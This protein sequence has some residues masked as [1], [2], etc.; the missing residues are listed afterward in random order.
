MLFKLIVTWFPS[1]AVQ[2]LDSFHVERVKLRRCKR[3]ALRMRRR[4][5]LTV[6]VTTICSLSCKCKWKW[7]TKLYLA[8]SLWAENA[9][10]LLSGLRLTWESWQN[11]HKKLPRFRN[12]C[13]VPILSTATAQYIAMT[14]LHKSI[15]TGKTAELA[16]ARLRYVAIGSHFLSMLTIVNGNVRKIF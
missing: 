14:G 13:N 8:L 4:M 2:L 3:T 6:K 7:V 16:L 12:Y 1:R 5:G 9:T 10:V 15:R 11:Y